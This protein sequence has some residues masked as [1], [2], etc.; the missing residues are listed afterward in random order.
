MN[1]NYYGTTGYSSFDPKQ[2][3]IKL[4]KKIMLNNKNAI[5]FL[6]NNDAESFILRLNNSIHILEELDL[7]LNRDTE[8]PTVDRVSL[9]Y[10]WM[11]EVFESI[12]SK[13]DDI[14]F[15][16]EQIQITEP[17]L[18]DLLDGFSEMRD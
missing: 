14:E 2:I 7:M 10:Q 6:E 4:M 5:K 8:N 15:C 1:A 17:V 16:I 3:V 12:V 18:K 13:P 9:H 11:I